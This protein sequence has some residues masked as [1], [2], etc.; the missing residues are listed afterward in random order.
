M[1]KY[2]FLISIFLLILKYSEAQSDTA[3]WF[4]APNVDIANYPVNGPY[5]RPIYLR[6]TS[7]T[8]SANVIISIPANIAFTPISI[9]IPAN[10]TSTIDLTPWID[11]IENF[12][13]GNINNK[14]IYIQSTTDI[15]AYYEVN[16]ITCKCNPE[17]FSLKGKN[18]IG[19]EFYI[20]SQVTWSIDTIR[21][22]DARA[23]FE[24]VATQN[25]TTITITPTKPLIGRPANVPFTITLNRGQT[26]SCQALYHDGPSLLNGSKIIS[27]KPIAVTTKEDLLFSDGPCADLAG[28]QLIPTAIFGNEYAVVRGDLTLRDKAVVTARQ[29]N[30]NIYL[31]G[32]P[33]IAATIN[34]GQSYEIDITALPS[35]YITANNAVSVFHYTGNGCEVGAA[36]IPKL[37]CTGSSSVSIVRSNI[38]NAIVLLVTKNG[39]QGN[40]LVNG[41][42]GIINAVDFSPLAGTGGN[43]VYAKKNLTGQMILNAAT[44]FSNTSGKFQLGFINGDPGGYMYGYFSDFKKSNVSN[45]QEEICRFDSVQLNAT[46]GV[47]YQWT[48]ATGLSNP[49]ISNPKASPAITTDYKVIIA[50]IDGCIDS[51]FVKV[52]VNICSLP[53]NNWLN[54]PSAGSNVK[55]GDLDVSGNQLTIEASFNRTAPPPTSGSYGFLVSKHLNA[56]D[57]NYSLWPNGCALTTTTNPEAFAMANCDI[58]LNKTY[59]VAMVYDGTSLKFYRNGFL[60]SQT[61]ISGTLIT[62]NL[63]TTIAENP[64]GGGP[65][66]SFL[67]NMN[68]VRIWNVA[69]T[70]AQLQTYMDASIPSPTTQAG[71]LGYYTFDNLLNKQGNPAYNG[72][73]NGGAT[74]NNTNPN[75]SFV[76]DSCAVITGISSVINT[77][78]PVLGF[79]PCD[80]KLTVEDAST[81]NVGDTVL[82]IQMKGAVIDSTNTALFGN[83]TNYNNSGNY[84]FNYVQS[85]TGNVIEL[86]N[87][88]TRQYDIPIGK[89]QLIRVPYY[90]NINII[91]TLTCL[92]WDG[93]KGGVLVLNVQDSVNL[94]A[95][96]N[97]SGKGFRGG[98]GYNP[99]NASLTCFQNNYFYPSNTIFAAQKGESITSISSNISCG[100]GTQ[101]SGGGGGQGHNSGGGGGGNGGIGGFGGYQLEPC[102]SAPYDNRGIGG[103]QP[104]YSTATNKIFMGGGG[105][106]GHADNPGNIP[107][108]GGN[109]AGIIIII[110]DKIV[111]NS[112]KIIANGNNGLACVIP[113]SPDCHD[114]MGGGGAGGTVLLSVNQYIDNA[115][116]ETKGGKGADMIG[117]VPIGGRI[118]AGGG[119]GGGLAFL[120]SATV[121]T[122]LTVT[123][124]GGANG[125]LT[126]DG[127]SS[128]GA[129]PG[130]NGSNLFN[131]V[132]PVDN[133]PFTPNIDS[134]RIKDSLLSCNGFDFKGL[135]YTNTN[136]I[137]IWQ[138]YFG[139]GGTANTQN[140]THAYTLAGTYTVKL[141]VTDINGCKDSITKNV[142]AL[143][144]IVADAG[145][146][147]SFCSNTPVTYVLQGSGVG[148]YSWTPVI[149]LNNPTLQNPTATISSTTKF[150]LT[151]TSASACNS[152]DSVTL[153]VNP[154]PLVQTLIDTAVCKN[155]VLVLTTTPGAGTY[156]WSPGIYVSDSTISNP[157]FI[158]TVSRTLIV[159][160]TNAFG[161]FSKDT[162][163]ITVKPLP[164]VQ[165]IKDS[166]ICSI[167]S[168]TLTTTGAQTYSWTPTVFLSNPNISNPVFSGNASQ[169]YYVTGTAANG[170]SAKDTVSVTVNQPMVFQAP[171]DKS[172]CSSSSVQLDGFNGTSVNYLWSPGTYLSSTTIINPIASP[173]VTTTYSVL[174]TD[175][176]CNINSSFNVQ[177]IVGAGP[178][179]NA[180]KS[181]DIDCVNK[182]A[183]LYASGGDTYLWTPSTGLSNPNIPNPVATPTVTQKYIVYVT[184]ASGC[185]NIDSVTVF[186]NLTAS[187]ARYIP[188]AFTPNGDGLNDCYGLKNW[189]LIRKLE[190]R[191]FNRYG[192]Q[193]FGTSD[194]NKCWDGT[195]KGKPALAGSYVF[196]I[197]A[198]TSCGTEEQKGNFIL[199]R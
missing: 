55:I 36:V 90:N 153:T 88:L 96:I 173:P 6:L 93:S 53:C 22:P 106:A 37:T 195:Y 168:I 10:S 140:T 149:Y 68:E 161:C 160:G 14:G 152:T 28:D 2:F 114:G 98:L 179:V 32:S 67:G 194:P 133:I 5:D 159:T 180:G 16:S 120:K 73:L 198:E 25:N 99:G 15:T 164:V 182:T 123:N 176:V 102:G 110:A 196:Y 163:N 121:P 4:A 184:T 174:I 71:L 158:D 118:G 191:V 134:V 136:P 41:A 34:A 146:D 84:E 104:A 97:V 185:S 166:T 74:I 91:D 122:N 11:L 9:T 78:T 33:T 57:N 27:D 26:Y 139:D 157:T 117:S 17:L 46:G 135:A 56:F 165:T 167:Q 177:V 49:N 77:Y 52:V 72:T 199:I 86:K 109:G 64:P 100:K 85:K 1:K 81:F 150:Y 75:C 126:Q 31:N 193:V 50:D 116:I 108:A 42:T 83:V 95:D 183:A 113:V 125:V 40:F 80:N 145:N 39:N 18:A 103:R 24:I 111:S 129:T 48:P 138:W 35:L 21:F 58:E 7:F 187:L 44:T 70:Q 186:S 63:L 3:F 132:V 137:S 47:T 94:Y 119:G 171:P 30:T 8:L 12:E 45:T 128:W 143:P 162:I 69:R 59:H 79:N 61:P 62:N 60:H 130:A 38:G 197:K 54:T 188:N 87:K 144:G 192:E 124:T 43:Y 141:V 178:T 127:N 51:A 112:K 13:P 172:M 175:P 105:G 92:P 142:N 101:A 154:V 148:T 19:N 155:S 23:A 147:T 76:A 115:N 189:M 131:L 151:V 156:N 82:M 170:C 190:F 89:V 107:P 20:P 65:I 169:V 29:N 66:F 181:N